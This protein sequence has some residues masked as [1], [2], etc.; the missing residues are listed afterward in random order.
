MDRRVR[1]FSL[2]ALV[3]FSVS[4]S[5]LWGAAGTESAAFLEIPIGARP[6]ALGGAYSA[7]ASDAYAP[8]WN[9][10]GLGFVAVPQLAAQH[11]SYLESVH[12]DYLSG[13]LPLAGGH[14]ALGASAQYL[15][16]GDIPASGP[17]G[18]SLG[19]FSSHYAAYALAYGRQILE[20]VSVGAAAKLINAQISNVNAN[21]YAVDAGAMARF[22]HLTLAAG[23]ANA[24][25]SLTFLSHKESPFSRKDGRGV[26]A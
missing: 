24:G 16:T 25:S 10:A 14:Q 8:T 15:G 7:L 13:V 11:V 22:H 2:A 21:T 9:P 6:A 18:A 26:P 17:T 20:N 23:M 1:P 4:P 19:T 5:H 12:Y 3:F